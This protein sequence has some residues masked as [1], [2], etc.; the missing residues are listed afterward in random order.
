MLSRLLLPVALAVVLVTSSASAKYVIVPGASAPALRGP[1]V[2]V[3]ASVAMGPGYEEQAIAKLSQ[4]L[5]TQHDTIAANY[6]ASVF[7]YMEALHGRGIPAGS[8]ADMAHE[9]L[10]KIVGIRMA[11]T[12]S[13]EWHSMPPL[14]RAKYGYYYS[15]FLREFN[16]TVDPRA[17]AWDL[18]NPAQRQ[19]LIDDLAAHRGDPS[20]AHRLLDSVNLARRNG[21]IPGTV[22]MP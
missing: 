12:A 1:L 8:T 11:A 13:S 4:E 10:A 3:G 20:Y 5:L 14:E 22:V 2:P 7:P 15:N 6:A 21:F 16:R 9:W 19:T 18:Y 17:F